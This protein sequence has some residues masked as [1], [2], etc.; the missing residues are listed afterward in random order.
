MTDLTPDYMPFVVGGDRITPDES[1]AYF[2]AVQAYVDQSIWLARSPA[3]VHR[4]D[5]V[6]RRMARDCQLLLLKNYGTRLGSFNL[7]VRTRWDAR[8][9][10]GRSWGGWRKDRP[11]ISIAMHRHAIPFHMMEYAS[12]AHDT[13]I[14]FVRT[15][16]REVHLAAIVAHEIA[17]AAVCAMTYD[18]HRKG[19]FTA[20][21]LAAIN[22]GAHD[23]GWK[24]IYRFLRRNY[25][26]RI[27]AYL[28]STACSHIWRNS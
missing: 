21:A 14:G 8:T 7:L 16:H 9:G 19:A 3:H 23:D 24:A 28:N 20:E 25:V 1:R 17:H 18:K 4:W 10:A 15:T 27:D 5:T 12:F 11:Y 6:I 26:Q 22:K 13:E 2:R